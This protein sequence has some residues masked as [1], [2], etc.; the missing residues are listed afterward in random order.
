[1]IRKHDLEHES[2]RHGRSKEL[3]A[4]S[5]EHGAG[6]KVCVIGLISTPASVSKLG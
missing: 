4:R 3:G 5:W 2:E 1:M 6:S